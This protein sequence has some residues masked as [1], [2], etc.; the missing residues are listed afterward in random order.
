MIQKMSAG[1]FQ[2]LDDFGH[3]E[4]RR[5]GHDE[6]NVIFDAVNRIDNRLKFGRLLLQ[7]GEQSLLHGG[8]DER[9][10][11]VRGPD[12]MVVGT[13]ERH[14]VRSKQK[15]RNV[16]G[17]VVVSAGGF[18]PEGG[19]FVRGGGHPPRRGKG[20]RPRDRERRSS[21]CVWL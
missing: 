3:G 11:I 14:D 8:V 5:N 12:E 21:L 13:P 20:G 17:G 10:A 1:P 4:A 16:R 18:S 15:I 6:V 2:A 19:G 9:L 7:I